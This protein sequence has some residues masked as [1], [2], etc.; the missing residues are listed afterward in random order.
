MGSLA[1]AAFYFV[2]KGAP[3]WALPVV[4]ANVINIVAKPNPNAMRDLGINALVMTLIF[5]ENIPFHC[6]YIRKLSFAARS[7]EMEL[8]AALVR[9][10]QELSI[11]FYKRT[12]VGALQSKILRDVESVDQTVR[13]VIDGGLGA[14]V[15]IIAA[16][17]VT[18]LRA[19]AFLLIFLL[20]VPIATG[21]RMFL[22]GALKKKNRA[23]RSEIEGMSSEISGMIE[24]IP[25]TR[26]HAVEEAEIARVSRKLDLVQHAGL[27]LDSQNALFQSIS[28]VSFGLFHIA[29]LFVGAWLSY[30]KIIPLP[31]GDIIMLSS[32]FGTISS[33]VLMIV[34]M[35]PTLTKGFESVR[36]IG[37]VLECPDF[38]KN[39]GKD[40]VTDV[41]G[42]FEFESVT[43]VHPGADRG[44]IRDFSLKVPPGETLAV[45]GASGAGKSTL[46]SLIL[47]FDRPT[48]GVIRLDGRD[49]N[50]IDLRS[51]RRF[52]GVVAQ[53]S[54]LFH[55]TLRENI[56]YGSRNV[57]DEVILQAI[58]D[59]N[60]A[61][62][63]DRLP[64]GLD[65]VVGE[66]GAR[67]SGGQKQRIA[68]ARALIRNP[69][70]LILDEATSALDVSSEKV[71]QGALDRLMEGRTT[72]IVAHRLSTIRN[73]NRVIVLEDGCIVEAGAP[74]E[75][76][77]RG[78]RFAEMWAMQRGA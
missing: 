11:S 52:V 48:S 53:D 1:L 68:I 2:I 8:R 65:T 41:R 76:R 37:E 16:V 72:F 10:M 77:A 34:N 61:E 51:F 17:V 46:M 19:P 32:F 71:V 36:S 56:V 62:F 28:W 26:A 31:P 69:R 60:A 73:A 75:L 20:A 45:I 33:A 38:E 74:D 42:E 59:A 24:M 64:D 4:T 6:L 43:F 25:I 70:I 63:V 12:S 67:L 39:L 55:G 27:E 18:Y 78:G 7:V 44:S 15:A 50:E 23:F 29:S 66:R 47:G 54:V 57:K 14:L 35:M 40:A 5:A 30:K 21:L 3:T 9:R 58:R 22:G 13:L 49:M